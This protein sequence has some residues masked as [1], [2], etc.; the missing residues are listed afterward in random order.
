MK[1]F[2]LTLLI[3]SF[4]MICTAS[5]CNNT[6]EVNTTQEN[7]TEVSLKKG[8]SLKMNQNFSES[9]TYFGK[10]IFTDVYKKENTVV[11]PLS[12]H[13]AF[14]MLYNGADGITEK[15][16]RKTLGYPE[17]MDKKA[18][19]EQSKEVMDSLKSNDD[20]T[21]EIANSLWAKKNFS[22]KQTFVENSKEYFYAEVKNQISSKLM[23]SWV[24]EKTHK[25]INKIV[26]RADNID[27]ALLNAIYFN[28]TWVKT[29]DKNNTKDQE[30]TTLA[31]KKIK[32]PMMYKFENMPYYENDNYQMV[33]LDYKG[34]MASMYVFL[35]KEDK[36]IDEFIK[37]FSQDEFL[38]ASDNLDRAKVELFLPKFKTECSFG[39]TKTIEKLGMKSAFDRRANFSGISSGLFIS[40]VI[41]KTYIDVN[42]TG[43]E[44]AAVTGIMMT[45]SAMP[46][47]V[48]TKH[49]KIDRPFFFVIADSRTTTPIFMGTITKPEYK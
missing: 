10:N 27:V 25:K 8:N 22:I 1:K 47:P 37:N 20:I 3:L 29:F 23:N 21:I 18:I 7:V 38:N 45:K 31:N 14:D 15:E 33:R 35:P 4:S 41:H 42:E 13:L 40:Q 26:D 28:G 44:A 11:S 36:S 6:Q 16:M 39:L 49:M 34:R 32:V 30:F 5:S 17:N 19:S 12:L 46:R 9:I 2:L 43:T 24:S 48:P